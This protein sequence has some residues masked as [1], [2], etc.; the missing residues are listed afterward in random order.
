MTSDAAETPLT[1]TPHRRLLVGGSEAGAV[2]EIDEGGTNSD[3]KRKG[4]EE[5]LVAVNNAGLDGIDGN[6][7]DGHHGVRSQ[8]IR[9]KVSS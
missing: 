6:V 1:T 7:D 4:G 8:R 2:R 9:R 3:G 5:T